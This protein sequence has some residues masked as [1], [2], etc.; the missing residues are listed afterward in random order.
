MDGRGPAHKFEKLGISRLA[1][2]RGSTDSSDNG[3]SGG[4][5]G[6]KHISVAAALVSALG[7]DHASKMGDAGRASR[8]A[9]SS[10]RAPSPQSGAA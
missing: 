4:G 10:R 6:D 2:E 9:F 3:M 5:G 1:S 8:K 7:R